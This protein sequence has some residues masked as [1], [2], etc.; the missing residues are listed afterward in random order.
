MG[1][2]NGRHYCFTTAQEMRADITA[3]RYVEHG[4]FGGNLYGTKLETVK[5][6]VRSGRICVLDC[7]P[8]VR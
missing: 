3:N 7:G 8:Q 4:E 1:E 2:I 5:A 6:I